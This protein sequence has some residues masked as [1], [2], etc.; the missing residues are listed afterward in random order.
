MLKLRTLFVTALALTYLGCDI[1]PRSP[2]VGGV[3]V[4]T[5][6]SVVNSKVPKAAELADNV[7]IQNSTIESVELIVGKN[8]IIRNVKMAPSVSGAKLSK[9]IIGDNVTVEN[10]QFESGFIHIENDVSISGSNLD[11]FHFHLGARSRLS[12][13]S[14]TRNAG[15]SSGVSFDA[16]SGVSIEESELS[17][18]QN[19]ECSFLIADESQIV[20]SRLSATSYNGPNCMD[21]YIVFHVKDS[22]A[23]FGLIS[24]GVLEM[25]ESTLSAVKIFG[26]RGKLVES[27]IKAGELRFA[28]DFGKAAQCKIALDKSTSIVLLNDCKT[29]D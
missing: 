7:F 29:S 6:P 15:D 12:A 14:I 13:L 4:E 20:K 24:G 17:A 9:V 5:P 25:I 1:E 10:S 21:G 16:G 23:E 22:S 3:D 26:P 2:S 18:S 28:R 19:A 27:T 8:S 11:A